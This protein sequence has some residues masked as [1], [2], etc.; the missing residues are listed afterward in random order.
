M[1]PK[2]KLLIIDDDSTLVNALEM[3]L[4]R[5]GFEVHLA[6]N[7]A[8]GLRAFYALRPDLVVL[9]VMMPHLSGFDVAAAFGNSPP[10]QS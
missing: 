2:A 1:D 9:D 10:R 7:G 5:E 8:E 4:V 6:P 3:Y